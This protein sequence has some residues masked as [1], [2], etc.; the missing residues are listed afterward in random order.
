MYCIYCKAEILQEVFKNFKLL[1]MKRNIKYLLVVFVASVLSACESY[2]NGFEQDPNNPADASAEKMIEGIMVADMLVHSGDL[3]RLSGMW[4]G[5]FTGADRQYLTLDSWGGSIASDYDNTWGNFYTG[6]IAQARIVQEKATTGNNLRL[7]GVAKVLEAH[8]L[9]TVTQLWGDVP[10]E[11]VNNI[12]SFPNPKYDSQTSVYAYLQ[13]L[14]T[15]AIADLAGTG[16]INGDIFYGGSSANWTAFAHSLKARYF[17]HTGD[18]ASAESEAIAGID[19]VGEELWAPFGEVFGG[20]FNPYYD[21]MEYNRPGYMGADNA[22]GAQ[23]LDPYDLSGSGLSRSNAKTNEE[24]RFN[25]NYLPYYEV[26]TPGYEPNFLSDFEYGEPNG[27]FAKEFPLF[28]AGESLLIIAEARIRANDVTGAIAA[29][30]NYRNYLTTGGGGFHDI[31]AAYSYAFQYDPYVLADF[32]AGG[33]VN[34]GQASAAE[35]VLYEI[36]EERYVSMVG[37]L[38]AFS[39]WRRTNNMIGVPVK[40][41]TTI[42]Q[43]FLYPQ[44]EINT[45]ANVPQ[46]LP[47]FATP[48]PMNN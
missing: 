45:N 26:Y 5:Y 48:T 11:E 29:Y 32:E 23:L 43:R 41:G 17:V 40:F 15:S 38:E 24:A 34:H 28:T 8:A 33:M 37:E 9:G 42:A 20:D 27:K 30:N 14:L 7:R 21:F 47:D 39:D 35:A 25:W 18:F 16:S 4:M 44:V 31:A 36:I 13:S 10:N 6:V 12:A 46:P 1:H 3:N 2:I 19:T 22:Y